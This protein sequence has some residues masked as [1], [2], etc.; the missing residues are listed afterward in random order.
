MFSLK[1]TT[2]LFQNHILRVSPTVLETIPCNNFL[3]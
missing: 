1:Q 3:N 2:F